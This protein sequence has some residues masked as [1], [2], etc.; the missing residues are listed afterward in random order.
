MP[1]QIL[2]YVPLIGIVVA[3]ITLLIAIVA[4]ICKI[5]A[6]YY[7]RFC[8]VE[9][10]IDTMSDDIESIKGKIHGK[11]EPSLDKIIKFLIMRG[12]KAKAFFVKRSPI[13]LTD[14]AR[15]ILEESGAKN[16]I[17]SFLD[18]LIA[19]IKEDK[20]KNALDVQ[21]LAASV[22]FNLVDIEEFKPIKE[23]I[24]Q[25]PK[26]DGQHDIDIQ[27]MIDLSA[28]YLRDKYLA[29]DDSRDIKKVE[30]I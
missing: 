6:F 28:L 24:Y 19:K 11:I 23:F 27:V 20:P 29:Q 26:Y 18:S 8:P 2:K 10:K 3:S 22:L 30:S 1:D 5:L 13:E 15:K 9:D 16:F 17:D 4:I 25:N 21:Q 14:L 12:P 7:K